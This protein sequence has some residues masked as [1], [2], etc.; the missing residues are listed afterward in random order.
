M[1]GYKPPTYKSR[2]RKVIND[3]RKQTKS[4]L[5]RPRVEYGYT[6]ELR[7]EPFYCTVVKVVG[8][9]GKVRRIADVNNDD[10]DDRGEGG[11]A[12]RI[13]KAIAEQEAKFMGCKSVFVG[14]LK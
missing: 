13:A 10:I 7:Y 9:N 12:Y 3:I 8:A 1:A 5:P 14:W 6:K 11:G 2:T 4:G